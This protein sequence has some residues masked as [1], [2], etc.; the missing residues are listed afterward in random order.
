M[1][2]RF[3]RD[4]PDLYSLADIPQRPSISSVCQSTGWW[5]LDQIYKLYPG[6]FTVVH[7]PTNHGKSTFLMNL[8]CNQWHQ[9]GIRTFAYLPENESH[10]RERLRLIYG[11][12]KDWD[13]FAEDGLVLASAHRRYTESPHDLAWILNNAY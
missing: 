6:Q 9:N 13:G 1:S 2:D 11:E 4:V 7:G 5:E 3:W 12:R 8:I 10:I